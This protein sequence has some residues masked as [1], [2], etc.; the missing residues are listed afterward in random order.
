QG[1][2]A[3]R[4][5]VEQRAQ[6]LEEEG[7]PVDEQNMPPRHRSVEPGCGGAVSVRR[8]KHFSMPSVGRSLGVDPPEGNGKLVPVGAGRQVTRDLA[9][10]SRD[11]CPIG[12]GAP[13]W[14]SRENSDSREGKGRV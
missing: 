6:S 4:R 12:S 1:L 9:P 2:G 7:L 8:N 10:P 3:Q 5:R 11:N 13:T 14:D